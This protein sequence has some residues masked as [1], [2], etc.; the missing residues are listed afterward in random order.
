MFIKPPSFWDKSG[1]PLAMALE[2]FSWL[3]RMGTA[4]HQCTKA[5]YRPSVPVISVG[6]IVL[7]GAGKTPVTLALAKI[8]QAK[9]FMPH[10]ISRG[11]GGAVSKPVQVDLSRHTYQEVGDEPLLLAKVVPTW[12]SKNRRVA[13]DLAIQAGA[14]VLLL[15]DAH[16]NQDL[17]KD[18]CFLVVNA[19]QGFGNGRIFPAGP[20]RQSLHSGLRN[21]TAMIFIGEEEDALPAQ[22]I[23]LSCPLIRA[24]IAPVEPI[25][26]PVVGFAGLGYP[27]KF[28]QT[29][30]KAGYQVLD[31]ISFADHYP[32]TP[33]D[34]QRLKKKAQEMQGLLIT[35]EKDYTRIPEVSREDILTL[36]VC[37]T[38]QE[39]DKLEKV[40][41]S[42]F[43][44][45]DSLAP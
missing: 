34:L 8:L 31:F 12:V 37:L 9:G 44:S 19:S 45:A 18:I 30:V 4:V 5:P 13:A 11:Y 35:T 16:Q 10:V 28:Y 14:D 26:C 41:Q 1:H 6:N 39:D 3:Y 21:T 23:D 43:K 20:L 22:L 36:P 33:E 15:D 32:Y 2:P 24:K 27:D 29:L 42:I 40:L 17:V 38:F 25:A 7:G